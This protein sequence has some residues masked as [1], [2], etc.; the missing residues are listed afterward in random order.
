MLH[1]FDDRRQSFAGYLSVGLAELRAS[2]LP[3]VRNKETARRRSFRSAD[4]Q[5][6]CQAKRNTGPFGF[7]R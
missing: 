6:G 3:I 7:R 2:E 4:G 1:Q 5:K